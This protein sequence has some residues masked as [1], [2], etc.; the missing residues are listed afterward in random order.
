M[1]G[2]GPLQEERPL[3]DRTS[4]KSGTGFRCEGLGHIAGTSSAI[5]C[6]GRCSQALPG[7]SVLLT[8]ASFFCSL[9]KK[10]AC[11]VIT[12]FDKLQTELPHPRNPSPTAAAP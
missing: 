5:G 7:V 9:I 4:D 8:E 10:R 11:D 2:G 12:R 3:L 1:A 6:R